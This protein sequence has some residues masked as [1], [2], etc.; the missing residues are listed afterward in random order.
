MERKVYS[1][2]IFITII[3]NLFS[4]FPSFP[5]YNLQTAELTD[6]NFLFIH[7][8]GID[9]CVKDITKIIRTEIIF[10][11]EEQITKEKIKNVIIKKFDDGYIICLI[12]DKIYIFD[13]SFFI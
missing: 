7:K 10:T 11:N 1:Q 6:G 8:Y 3:I 2:L 4:I 9:I 5:F 12:I 13:R